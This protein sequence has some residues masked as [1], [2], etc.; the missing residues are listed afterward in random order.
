M[1]LLFLLCL[2]DLAFCD[3]D[4][5]DPVVG[6]DL[7]TTYSS[8]GI[9]QNGRVVIIPN[10]QGNLITPSYVAFNDDGKRLI[11]DSAKI[12]LASNPSNTIFE[13]KRFI[14]RDW[15][16]PVV[17]KYLKFYRYPFKIIKKNNK[18]YVQVSIGKNERVFAPEEISAMVLGKMKE[19]AEEYLNYK[20][21]KAVITVPANFNHAQRQATKDA[22]TI[23]GLDV[24]RIINEPTAAVLASGLNKK[25]IE[26]SVLA[27][28]FG[29]GSVDVSLLHVTIDEGVFEVLATSGDTNL[30][31]EDINERIMN[32]MFK[33]YKNTTGID[34]SYNTRVIEQLRW[35]IERAKRTLSYKYEARIE[36]YAEE[37]REVFSYTLTR[38]LFEKLNMDLF[39]SILNPIKRVL[40]D[41]GTKVSDVDEVIL[42]GGSTL[43]PKV[44]QLVKEF[45]YGKKLSRG[46][47]LDESVAF[48]AA[49]QGALMSGDNNFR[50][51]GHIQVIDVNPL[52]LGIET[53]S[54]GMTKIIPRNSA[55]PN[56]KKERVTTYADNQKTVTISVYEGEESI[57]KNNQLLGK[58]DLTGIQPAPRGVPQIDVIFKI[59][60]NSILTVSTEEISTKRNIEIHID[61]KIRISAEEMD[62]MIKDAETFENE[63][64]QLKK[65]DDAKNDLEFFAYLLKYQI[66]DNGQLSDKLSEIDTKVIQEAVKSTIRW[67]ESNPHAT[68]D[69]FLGMK[70][71]FEQIVQPITNQLYPE[72]MDS[73]SKDRVEL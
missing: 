58:F 46:L 43:I 53:N 14:G 7:G 23:A 48:G 22:A 66:S 36:I 10:E 60:A 9:F 29:G 28:S 24:L 73:K 67:I 38:T 25:G 68:L 64:K 2:I 20:V 32:F 3:D 51:H 59:D 30:G 42:V 6:I 21:K 31:G 57:V 5:Q 33:K 45:F 19:I 12:Q 35:D 65:I 50:Y 11:G 26:K 56:L 54:G 41:S 37:N 1:L 15:D 61:S 40:I 62:K 18:P 47:N 49:V 16:D 71:K 39:D 72:K 63:G 55:I 8:V 69:D 27:F 4:G 17:Q 52:T 44:Q 34:I 70:S 13:V